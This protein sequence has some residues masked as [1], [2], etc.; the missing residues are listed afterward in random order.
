LVV[1][2][3]KTVK[4][5]SRQGNM[6]MEMLTMTCAH[7]KD[8]RVGVNVV[9][10]ERYYPGERDPRLDIRTKEILNGLQFGDF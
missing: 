3:Q 5:S 8:K 7:P 4:R 9:Y 1:E 2:D 10:S 6:V